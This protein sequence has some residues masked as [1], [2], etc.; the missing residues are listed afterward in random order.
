M[1][2]ST[3]ALSEV[4]SFFTHLFDTSGF[5]PRWQCGTWSE[6][7]G[8]LHIVSDLGVWSAYLAIPLVLWYF[9]LRRRN[10]PFRF[11]FVLFGG[12]ILFCGTTH[13]MEAII[14]WWPAYRLAGMIK[15]A[16]AIISWATVIALVPLAPKVL[17]MKSP[18]ELEEVVQQRTAELNHEIAERKR[19]ERTVVEQSQLLEVTLSSIGDAVIATDTQ[20]R[21]TFINPIAEKLTGWTDA[22]ARGRPLDEVFRIINEQTRQPVETPCDAVLR[23]GTIVGLANHTVL[24]A[25]DGRETPIDDSAA[26]IR[27]RDG[28]VFGVVLVFRDA[29]E[30]RGHLE[31]KERLAAIVENSQ[32]AIISQDLDGRILTWNRGAEL[33]FGYT[34]DEAVGNP[35]ELIVPQEM[36]AEHQESM[37]AL[38]RGEP[39]EYIESSRVHKDGTR[40]EV[41]SRISPLRNAE[42]EVVGASKLSHDISQRKRSERALQLY[43][44][45]GTVL[46]AVLDEASMLARLARV[47]VPGFA[48]WCVVSIVEAHGRIVTVGHAHSDPEQQKVLDELLERYP[49]NWSSS[50]ID[51]SV[52]R[53][54]QP[55]LISDMPA[56]VLDAMAEDGPYRRLIDRLGPRSALSVPIVIRGKPVG[57]ISFATA[58]ANRRYVL[59]D[60]EVAVEFSR[61][62][63]HAIENARLYQDLREAQRQKDDFLAMLAHELRNP[64]AAIQYANAIARLSDQPTPEAAE[65]S[66]TIDR[67]VKNLAHLIDDLL[68][69]SRITRDKIQLKKEAVDGA[70]IV[71]R[72]V[73]SI[74]PLIASRKH[75]LQVDIADGEL[76][77][78]ADPTRLEQILV[79]LLS[80]AAKYTPEGGRIAI[81]SFAEGKQAVFEVQDNGIGIPFDALPRVFELFTQVDKSLDRSQG[82]LGIGLTVVRRLTEMHGGTVQVDSAGLGQGSVFTVRLPLADG[83][84]NASQPHQHGIS[85]SR[86]LKI[87]VVDDNLDTANSV[88]TL[89]RM[90]GHDV[91]LAH[92]GPA[93]LATARATRP[94][95]I[96]L[97]IG[98]P[99]I[100]GYTVARTLR[101][102]ESF[103]GLRLIAVSGYGQPDDRR[104][105]QEAGFDE[106]LVKPVEFESLL[107]ALE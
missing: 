54:G 71:R 17:S 81:R 15:L 55:E 9:V 80:N 36:R 99:G 107:A 105:S 98:L 46:S 63:A 102:D 66:H 8:W 85:Q 64:L 89:L 43:S 44:D 78:E 61:R 26:P 75:E 103:A 94:E 24:I 73:A 47:A 65:A 49:L 92:D 50:S 87:L 5:P 23:D 31:A 39:V 33:L 42:G 41:S 48:D 51:V 95:V 69:V 77:L 59:E 32:D 84:T 82:G 53:S 52:L 58:S 2:A 19:A 25:Q 40:L 106:H 90:A 93:A 27:D 96:V 88:A 45:A 70:T 10:L 1:P 56:A 22:A 18:A 72:A 91:N 74:Q 101:D 28:V 12:F 29:T 34:S 67:Q 37:Q 3:S 57:V 79:N 6:G 60:V 20:A 86:S 104:R 21:I 76:P 38:R 4:G 97:D 13:L 11:M 7:H 62:A 68:D 83:S 16:T 30:Q 35:I 14:F 100:D